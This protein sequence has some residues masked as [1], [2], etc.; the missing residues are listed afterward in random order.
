[1]WVERRTFRSLDGKEVPAFSI[2]TRGE[3]SL[4]LIH[5]FSSS[6]YEM[7]GIAYR[8]AEKGYDAFA[9]DIR[10]HGDNEN[11]FD[12]N[13]LEDVE[14]VI[15]E[16]RKKYEK[17]FTLGHSLG[18]LLSLK[19]S[20]DF[21]FAI[22]PPLMA[23]VVPEVEFMLRV[24]ACKVRERGDAIFEILRKLNPP[25]REKDAIVFYGKGES[26]AL[27]LA[28]RKWAEG[29]DVKLIEI[30]D[31]QASLP[32]TEVDAER[33]KVYVPRFVSHQ[34]VVHSKKLIE[35]L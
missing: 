29:R 19:S 6:K 15:E 34:A 2:Q 16:L 30:D 8:I 32:Q 26:D 20:S 9:I 21:A 31:M 1:M 3:S 13:V 10:G 33:L 17:V 7:L 4:I 35:F 18:G 5:G 28:I 11:E 23:K 27:K 25:E 14:G 12:D 22:S 24:H